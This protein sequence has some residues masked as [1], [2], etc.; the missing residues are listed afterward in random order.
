MAGRATRTA[1]IAA[2]A[3]IA[4]GTAAAVV[5]VD[6][7]AVASARETARLSVESLAA[8]VRGSL[9]PSAARS[10]ALHDAMLDLWRAGVVSRETHNV[11]MRGAVEANPGILG[12]WAGWEPNAFDGMDAL[13]SATPQS[14][15]TGRFIP[16]WRRAGGEVSLAPLVD[17]DKP[18]PGDYYQLALKT[19]QPQLIEPYLYEIEGVQVLMTTL[20]VPLIDKGVVKGVAG[21]D[22]ALSDL[23]GALSAIA[24]PFGG[25]VTLISQGGTVLH[26]ADASRL[27][28]TAGETDVLAPARQIADAA[29]GDMLRIERPV[30]L[31][32][33]DAA[34]TV[35][36][37]LPMSAV[38]ADARSIQS[39]LV[40]AAALMLAT[41]ALALWVGLTRMVGRPM[42]RLSTEMEALAQG[43]LTPPQTRFA[44]ADELGRMQAD[45]EVFRV[46]A[47]E[48]T[49]LEAELAQQRTASDDLQIQADAARRRVL[50]ALADGLARLAGGDLVTVID[51][52]FDGE[53]D[54]LRLDYNAAVARLRSSMAMVADT[55]GQLQAGS[56]QI[57][58]A[59]EGMTL[60]AKRQAGQL[61]QTGTA[62]KRIAEAVE[63]TADG[64]RRAGETMSAARQSAGRGNDTI[65]RMIAAMRDIDASSREISDITGLIDEIA[66]QTNLLALNAGVEAARAGDAGRG[67][68]VVAAE[69]RALAHRSAEAARKIKVLIDISSRQVEAGVQLVA[70][71]GETL[72]E[73][74]GHVG[75]VSAIVEDI[76]GG[77]RQQVSH[78]SDINHAM[79][80]MDK[81]ARQS[82]I[83][84]DHGLAAA[85][86]LAADAA[87]LAELLE[88][89]A[90][91]DADA[92][93][94]EGVLRAAG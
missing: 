47:A 16:Y 71:S 57:N 41:L 20:S 78:L 90:I 37:D 44:K 79:A 69:V 4:L 65:S 58:R 23:Q 59:A 74:A 45:I 24:P 52:T 25:R 64:A 36:L 63:Q 13:F 43:D 72:G 5:V 34:W 15:A 91:D 32:G 75:G 27:G 46:Q 30:R 1:I 2:A 87:S 92:G 80:D 89:F 67:F 39:V 76:S 85:Q 33:F 61:A 48:R 51:Q 22:I 56:D 19:G 70:Q 82:L 49:R 93:W 18:G 11:L 42:D 12:A 83:I 62:V 17:Y 28:Q 7:L 84:A 81:T 77:V 88:S 54:Q 8:S 10:F 94:G 29:A 6:R 31:D 21:L 86:G 3:V 53:Y 26:D 9:Q 66:F 14:D 40:I 60:R 55:A 50:D 35:R 73:I 38:M 68:A